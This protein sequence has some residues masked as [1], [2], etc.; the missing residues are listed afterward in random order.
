MD[1][2]IEALVGTVFVIVIVL[3]VGA[4]FGVS[5]RRRVEKWRACSERTWPP[6]GCWSMSRTDSSP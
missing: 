1:D 6:S 2:L 5:V 3:A 4:V